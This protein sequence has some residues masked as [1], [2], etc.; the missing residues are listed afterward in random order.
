MAHAS[1]IVSWLSAAKLKVEEVPVTIRY[2]E[3]SLA[4]GQ[5]LLNSF[6]II[7]ES[8]TGRLAQ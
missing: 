8:L 5:S 1:E 2:T 6:N 7:W 3:Y 4:K